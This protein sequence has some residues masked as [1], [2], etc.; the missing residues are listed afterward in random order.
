MYRDGKGIGQSDAEAVRLFRLAADQ[1]NDAAQTNLGWMYQTG[2]GVVANP[3]EAIRL[4]RL[5]ARQGNET[6][7]QNLSNMGES[8]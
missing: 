7:Q 5:A 1:N 6:A 2:R 3:K 8:W 4:Y